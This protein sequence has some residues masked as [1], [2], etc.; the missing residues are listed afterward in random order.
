MSKK[1]LLSESQIRRFMTLAN[2]EPL[3]KNVISEKSTLSEGSMPSMPSGM[4]TMEVD[5]D[6]SDDASMDAAGEM[7]DMEASEESPEMDTDSGA[8]LDMSPDVEEALEGFLS[9]VFKQKVSLSIDGVEEPAGDVDSVEE[10][11][12]D[13]KKSSSEKDEE[14]KEELEEDLEEAK[15]KPAKKAK[16]DKK[17]EEEEMDESVELSEDSLVE[18]VLARVTARLVQEAKKSSK[19]MSP[20]EKAEMKKKEMEAKKKKL[21]EATSAEGGGP[22]LKQGKNKY[23]VY[24]GHADMAYAKGK[25]GKGGHQMETMTAKAEHTVTHGGKNLATLGGNNKKV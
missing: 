14:M 6:P 4:P 18:A 21:K 8:A 3:V 11:A 7:P 10:P 16:D 24:K 25:E 13:E 15:K 2:L 5:E 17:E 12:A 23:D 1:E 20:K 22:L 19:K 9:A